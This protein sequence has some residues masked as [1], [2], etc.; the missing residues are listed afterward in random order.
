MSKPLPPFSCTH[1]P[2]IPELLWQLNC[3]VAITTY[4]AG[5]VVLISA[6]NPEDLVQLPRNFAKPMGM[7][8]QGDKLALATRGEVIVLKNSPQLATHYPRQPETYDAMYVPR[9]TYFTGTLDLHDIV[10]SNQGLLAVNTGFSCLSII[11]E[12]HSFTPIWQPPF[13]T[14]IAPEDRCHLNGVAL[15]DGEPEYVTALG[16][17]DTEGGWRD[18]KHQGG[19]LMHVPTNEII[20][21]GLSMPHT[22]RLYNGKLYALISG[23]GEL[24]EVF[25]DKYK[26]RVVKEL[27]GFVRGMDL[28]D[29]YLFVGLS[30]LRKTSKAFQNLPISKKSAFSGVVVIHLPTEAIVGHIQ[31]QTSVEEIYEVRVL[32]G[33]KRPGILNTLKPEFRYC[34]TTPDSTFWAPLPEEQK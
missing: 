4:Q 3:T 33:M 11:D 19:I 8:A 14:K 6:Q 13:I 12:E 15:K 17:T 30:K 29:D 5:K 18:N 2:N 9:S 24:V 28:L 27:N 10:Y 34:L 31:Y 20:L 1:S 32:P 21:E 25:P 22:P 16:A 7:A 23:T 26:Y